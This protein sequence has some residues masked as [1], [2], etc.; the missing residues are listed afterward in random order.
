VAIPIAI[1]I[2]IVLECYY[3]PWAEARAAEGTP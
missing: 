3:V 1:A 2:S